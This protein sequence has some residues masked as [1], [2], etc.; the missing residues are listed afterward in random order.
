MSTFSFSRYTSIE[1]WLTKIK[2][3]K[4]SNWPS[5]LLTASEINKYIYL[6]CSHAITLWPKDKKINVS[7]NSPAVPSS[8]SCGSLF[9]PMAF[10]KCFS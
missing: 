6:L 8:I 5:A 1:F 7:D 9:L 4:K 10:F 3:S 2:F